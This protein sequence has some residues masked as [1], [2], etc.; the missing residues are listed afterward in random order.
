MKI[1]VYEQADGSVYSLWFPPKSQRN[2]WCNP[3]ETDEEFVARAWEKHKAANG[4]DPTYYDFEPNKLPDVKD[5]D[6]VSTR[7]QW[8]IKNGKVV[9][10]AT[11]RN[12]QKEI[13]EKAKEIENIQKKATISD[14]DINDIKRKEIERGK[15]M[16]EIGKNK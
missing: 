4:I 5:G 3:E 11:V 14:S 7:E 12:I 9:I 1:R 10:D 16:K 8:R 2:K 13:S 15:L 6:G